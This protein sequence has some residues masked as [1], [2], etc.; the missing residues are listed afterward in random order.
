MVTGDWHPFVRIDLDGNHSRRPF[1][2]TRT[3]GIRR[4]NSPATDSRT[5]VI[6]SSASESPAMSPV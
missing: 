4:I 1:H 2:A 3:D 5:L 6:H